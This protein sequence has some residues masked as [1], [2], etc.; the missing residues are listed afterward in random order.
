LAEPR[1]HGFRGHGLSGPAAGEEPSGVGVGRGLGVRSL[2]QVVEQH[3]VERGGNGRRW[4]AEPDEDF[5]VLVLDVVA[6]EPGDPRKRLGV[7]E[8]KDGG[9]AILERDVVVVHE[10]SQQREPLVLGDRRGIRRRAVRDGDGRHVLGLQVQ[11]RKEWVRRR[12]V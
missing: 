10:L 2:P 12:A 8:D 1:C 6:A 7:E 4:I 5:A 9:H 11:R 3:S